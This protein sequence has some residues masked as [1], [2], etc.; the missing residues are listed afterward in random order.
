[1]KSNIE[2]FREFFPMKVKVTQG[3]IKGT[4]TMDIRTCIGSKALQ[5]GLGKEGLNLLELNQ[6]SWGLFS[7]NQCFPCGGY[8]TVE[9]LNSDGGMVNMAQVRK[10]IEVTL[11]LR[12]DI[13]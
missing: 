12:N 5:K 2:K 8:I 9:S 13:L 7:G 1:M 6:T 4:D 3:M 10:P 11:K